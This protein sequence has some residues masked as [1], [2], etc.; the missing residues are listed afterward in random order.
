MEKL[1]LAG[2]G[3]KRLSTM[4]DPK[5]FGSNVTLKEKKAAALKRGSVME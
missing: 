1:E 3:T 4:M 2:A 5:A